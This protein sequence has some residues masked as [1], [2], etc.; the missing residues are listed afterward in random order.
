M[1]D[2]HWN[3]RSTEFHHQ[4]TP[5][6]NLERNAYIESGQFYHG[7]NVIGTNLD[8][9]LKSMDRLSL[10]S[11]DKLKG[12]DHLKNARIITD[13][14]FD[15]RTPNSLNINTALRENSGRCVKTI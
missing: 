14:T 3:D 4:M 6:S 7:I 9:H 5:V 12:F 15:G 2:N 8:F 11:R 10:P 13:Q 1:Q